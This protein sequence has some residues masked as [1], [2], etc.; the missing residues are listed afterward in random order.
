M[1]SYRQITAGSRS[2]VTRPLVVTRPAQRFCRSQLQYPTAWSSQ[3]SS[4]HHL[5][6]W[7]MLV[8]TSTISGA[9]SSRLETAIYVNTAVVVN[10][11]Q[12]RFSVVINDLRSPTLHISKDGWPLAATIARTNLSVDLQGCS[13][14]IEPSRFSLHFR[15]WK[16][17]TH[18]A[19]GDAGSFFFMWNTVFLGQ[20]FLTMGRHCCSRQHYWWH[21]KRGW[22]GKCYMWCAVDSSCSLY[23]TFF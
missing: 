22:Q 5:L 16:R 19:R 17:F 13:Y 4:S 9:A 20:T 7:K 11:W 8:F 1:C 15:I 18:M 3:L 23:F 6:R 2:T 21:L 14:V 12:C 10:Q